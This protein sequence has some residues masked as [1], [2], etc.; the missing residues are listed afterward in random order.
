[1][2]SADDYYTLTL[3][4]WDMNVKVKSRNYN[5]QNKLVVG[6]MKNEKAGVAIEEFVWSKFD[7]FFIY[8]SSEHKKAKGIKKNVVAAISHVE[9]KYFLLNNECLTRSM[10][11]IQSK[12][13]RIGTYEINKISLSWFDDKIYILNT[14]YNRLAIGY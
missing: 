13:H 5:D 14:G 7:S 3:I 11:R 4:V 1:M 10:N 2:V 9:Y 12:N 8:D 6:K